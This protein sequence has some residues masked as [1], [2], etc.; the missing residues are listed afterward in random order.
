[1]QAFTFFVED[2][3]YS[4]PSMLIVEAISPKRARELALAHMQRSP[5]YT[6]ISV[7][8]ED[9]CLFVVPAAGEERSTVA[10]RAIELPERT[11]PADRSTSGAVCQPLPVGTGA[12][13][14]T[15]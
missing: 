2:D 13:D 11:A 12:D 1:M 3:R 15:G 5:H 7:Y 10:E 4:I 14:I 8:T 6:A 9:E